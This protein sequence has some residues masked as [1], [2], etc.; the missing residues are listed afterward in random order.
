MYVAILYQSTM[1]EIQLNS[2]NGILLIAFGKL[3]GVYDGS[4]FHSYI[5]NYIAKYN[6]LYSTGFLLIQLYSN[7][8]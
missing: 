5:H 4:W 1:I 3:Q 6:L 2:K 8:L 7:K